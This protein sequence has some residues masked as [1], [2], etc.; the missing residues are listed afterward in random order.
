MSWDRE[1]L[2]CARR[3][4]GHLTS[5]PTVRTGDVNAGWYSL[6]LLTAKTLGNW[7]L[8]PRLAPGP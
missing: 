3:Q 2:L 8:G 1:A 4:S 6:S 7:H 5:A